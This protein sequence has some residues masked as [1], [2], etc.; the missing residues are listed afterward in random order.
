MTRILSWNILHGG[1]SRIPDILDVIASHEPDIVTLQEMRRGK[2]EAALRAGL[3]HI[4]L[5]DIYIPDTNEARENTILVAAR[6]SFEAQRW[7]DDTGR[8]PDDNGLCHGVYARFDAF[9]IISLHFPQKKA[10]IPLF[11]A[12]LDLPTDEARLLIGDM[13]CGIPFEDSDTKTFQNTHLFQQLLMRGWTDAWRSRNPDAREFS[14]IS[15]KRRNGFRYDHAL[16]TA[17]F[18]QRVETALY[19]HNPREAGISDHSLLMLNLAS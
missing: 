18:D 13:N 9:E 10:Q 12:L 14:W 16:A 5:T 4:G 8:T 6:T 17:G 1:G 15:A 3:E 7:P 2:G 19:D 11:H